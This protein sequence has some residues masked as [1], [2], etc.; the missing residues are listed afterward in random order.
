MPV[1]RRGRPQEVDELD[2]DAVP[3]AGADRGTGVLAVYEHGVDLEAVGGRLLFFPPFFY[4]CQK[5]QQREKNEEKKTKRNQKKQK[6]NSPSP[7]WRRT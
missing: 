7:K 2:D 3:G 6:H 4:D 5:K 1:D